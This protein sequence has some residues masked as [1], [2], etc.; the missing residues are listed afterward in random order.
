MEK[1]FWS[2]KLPWNHHCRGTGSFTRKYEISGSWDINS[3]CNRED[4]RF[5]NMELQNESE[6]EQL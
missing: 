3:L 6:S 2:P 5:E 1:Q 4:A